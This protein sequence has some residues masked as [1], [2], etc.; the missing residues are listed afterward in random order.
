MKLFLTMLGVLL[1]AGTAAGAEALPPHPRLLFDDAGIA[2]LKQRVQQEPWASQWTAF[3]K[4]F[5][6]TM[7]APIELPPRGGN[8]FHWYVCPTHGARL[9]QGK[10]LGPWHW[11]HICPVDKEV[12]PGDPTKPDRDFDGVAINHPHSSYATAIRNAG[13]LFQIT[14]DARY[15]KRGRD[16]LLAYAAR[17]LSYPLHTTRGQAKIGGGRVGPQT[18]DEAMWLIPVAQGADLIWNTLA[19]ADRR[20]LADKLFLPAAR[21]VI[22]AHKM[23]VHNIQC[24]KNSAVGITGYL[25]GDTALISAAIDDPV[26]GYRTQMAKGVQPDGVWYEGAWGYHFF[27][28][29]A[30]WPLTEAARNCHLNL[31]GEP[32]KKM[33]EAP[34]NLAM[35]NLSL[36]AFNDSGE[37]N[38]RSSVFEL[39]YARYRDPVYLVALADSK[40]R[41]E[42]AL[43]FGVPQLPSAQHAALPSRN[44]QDSGYAILQRGA[45]EQATWLCLKYGPHGGGHG[46]PDKNNFVLYARGKVLCPDPGTR[47]YGSPLHG[48]WDKVTLAHNTLVV[49]EGNQAEAT[50]Q[51]LA[52]GNDHG[53]DFAMTDAGPIAKGVRFIRTAVMLNQ[54]LIIFS[55][56]ITADKPHTFDLAT[57]CNGTWQT[58]PPGGAFTLPAQNGYQHLKNATL[59]RTNA[60]IAQTCNLAPDWRGVIALAA[61]EPTDVITTTG[62]GKSTADRIPMTI[63]RR[64]TAQ[65]TFVWAL[66]LDGTAPTLQAVPP[67]KTQLDPTVAIR[68]TSVAN[69][70]NLAINTA[71]ATVRITPLAD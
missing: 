38:I 68:V 52:F 10:Q 47:P 36:P 32:L 22:L 57:H 71:K 8:W 42:M 27:T 3:R 43:W 65:T 50:G 69:S 18:L 44:A 25:L 35:P 45:G 33:F 66:A 30:L 5:D 23:G 34:V 49:D 67:K 26:R 46:H 28:L 54:N 9:T 2:Q 12:L 31:Y 58:P 14:G 20:T 41:D 39:A 59:C 64:T 13:I 11:E 7:N 61:G 48:Q 24:W 37:V 15:A 40:R 51:C 17:Y 53:C 29:G 6:K 70:W 16:I 56:Q 62:V 21:D 63:F 19:E 1:L 60:A 55:D 4:S